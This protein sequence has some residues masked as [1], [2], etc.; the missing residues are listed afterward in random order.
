MDDNILRCGVKPGETVCG[1]PARAQLFVWCFRVGGSEPF[2]VVLPVFVCQE[3]A[4]NDVL[5]ACYTR[6][7]HPR[8]GFRAV[9]HAVNQHDFECHRQG[10]PQSAIGML[11]K[12]R[13]KPQWQPI[14]GGTLIPEQNPGVKM[15]LPDAISQANRIIH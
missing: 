11:D 10:K 3:H 6:N 2:P 14:S 13:C 15:V 9:Q 12:H 8:G 7:S 4:T 1:K 5:H